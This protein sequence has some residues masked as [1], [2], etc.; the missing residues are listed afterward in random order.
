M[1]SY[2]L[3]ISP[4]YVSHWGFWEAIRELVQNAYDQKDT[5]PNCEVT[6]DWNDEIVTIATSTGRLD[7]S[8][9]VL[10]NTTKSGNLRGK[11]GEGYKLALLVL[12]RLGHE[13][14]IHNGPDE[15]W[16]SSIQFKEEFQSEVLCIDVTPIATDPGVRFTIHGVSEEL[17]TSI[18]DNFRPSY[19]NQILLES[20]EKGRIYVGGLFVS[21]VK[22]EYG[23][24]FRAG[25]ISLDRDRGMVD[26]FDLAMATSRLWG[27]QTSD[28]QVYDL[29][30]ADAPDVKYCR[31]TA[32][33]SLASY[34]YNRYCNEYSEAT[35][36]VTTQAEIQKATAAGRKWALVPEVVRVI[37]EK[38]RKWVIPSTKTPVERLKDLRNKISMS[39]D[40]AR[41][42]DE[43][44]DLLSNS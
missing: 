30:K 38:V 14:R 32:E 41:E 29:L 43:I 40:D 8:S 22:F 16:A 35:V 3:P 10:G 44:I 7:R 4:K 26:D 42:F 15:L 28:N 24:S 31:Y 34:V 2:I 18:S 6:I 23:Y 20:Q 36:P 33:T 1:P 13:T 27:L 25:T 39:A 19:E 11:F 9:L 12:A 5:D 37:L 17:W 21:E